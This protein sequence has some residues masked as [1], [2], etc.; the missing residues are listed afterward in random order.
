MRD[1]NATIDWNCLCKIVSLQPI[2]FLSRENSRRV[3]FLRVKLTET[4]TK[5]QENRVKDRFSIFYMQNKPRMITRVT[6]RTE[7]NII[8]RRTFVMFVNAYYLT[9]FSFPH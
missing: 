6:T 9:I 2:T 1:E 5:Y 3:S 7:N 8:Q 4:K